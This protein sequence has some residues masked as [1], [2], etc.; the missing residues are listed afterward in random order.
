MI[1]REGPILVT[2]LEESWRAALDQLARRRGWPTSDEV[3]RLA[4]GVARLSASYNTTHRAPPRWDA[5][6]HAA[7]LLFFFPRDVAKAMGAL[8]ELAPTM[9]DRPLRVLDVGAGCG[10]TSL[11]AIRALRAAGHDHPIHVTAIDL[12][13][14]ALSLLSEVLGAQAELDIRAFDAARPLVGRFDLILLGQVLCELD[15][16]EGEAPRAAQHAGW[17]TSL[18][19]DHL[20]SEGALVVAEPALRPGTRHLHA[21]RDVLVASG[22][23]VFSPCPHAGAC[24]ML[25]RAEDWC[26]ERL[27]VD[28]PS[29][30]VPVARAAGLRWEGLTWAP[31]VLRADGAR[32]PGVA[33]VVGD[34]IVTKGRRDLWVCGTF[35]DPGGG[36]THDRRKVGRLDRH[37]SA[38]NAA[39]GD[40]TRGERLD[41]DGGAVRADDVVAR[42]IRVR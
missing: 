7:R 10:A 32:L 9:P 11:G 34:P 3:A 24:P 38:A 40:A 12:D 1:Q 16:A 15:L 22:L 42:V 5:A 39:F 18:V 21:V 29:W 30:L 13:E 2:A 4:D 28:L 37:A 23:R 31:L 33:R 35:A 14:V 6:L 17:L 20:T 8:R 36:V 27:D 26:H 41:L 25:A 19:R